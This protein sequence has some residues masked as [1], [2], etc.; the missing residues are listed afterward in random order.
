MIKIANMAA[1]NQQNAL[2]VLPV[3][4]SGRGQ[5]HFKHIDIHYFEYE[6]KTNYWFQNRT[7]SNHK[8]HLSI[9]IY[10]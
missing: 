10:A 5:S 6:I 4:I 8:S 9:Y 3:C 7:T 2:P 1:Q